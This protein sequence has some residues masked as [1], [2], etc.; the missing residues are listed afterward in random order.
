MSL[1]RTRTRGLC[2]WSSIQ[3]AGR[4]LEADPDERFHEA[5]AV[6]VRFRLGLPW[7]QFGCF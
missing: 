7:I 4:G 2:F 3:S 5:G 1:H 6:P